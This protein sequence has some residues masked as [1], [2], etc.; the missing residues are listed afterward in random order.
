[1]VIEENKSKR[2]SWKQVKSWNGLRGYN[3]KP[4]QRLKIYVRNTSQYA[5]KSKSKP[6]VTTTPSGQKFY[7]V[8]TGDTL[9]DIANA[10]GTTVNQ[11]KTL[12]KL[13]SSRLKVGQRLRVN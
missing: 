1:M 9:W 2:N 13:S 12:N 7:T 5:Q 3:I 10:Q 8:R 6:K 11:I 4:G